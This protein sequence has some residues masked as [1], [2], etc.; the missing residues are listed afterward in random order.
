M[1]INESTYADSPRKDVWKIE[2]WG[3]FSFKM[4]RGCIVCLPPTLYTE[5]PVHFLT[6]ILAY[7]CSV[8]ILGCANQ[9]IQQLPN[10]IHR[11]LMAHRASLLLVLAPICVHKARDGFGGGTGRLR[12]RSLSN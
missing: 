2:D 10:Q 7:T 8:I 12:K 6:H 1:I 9:S 11:C 4:V 5:K 3:L